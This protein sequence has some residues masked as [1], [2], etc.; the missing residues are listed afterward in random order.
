[1][2]KHSNLILEMKLK[3]ILYFGIKKLT[4]VNKFFLNNIAF[5]SCISPNSYSYSSTMPLLFQGIIF[6]IKKNFKNTINR[7]LILEFIFVSRNIQCSLIKHK[8]YVKFNS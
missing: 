5:E 7:E 8:L 2:K 1:M 3:S 4:H 6:H